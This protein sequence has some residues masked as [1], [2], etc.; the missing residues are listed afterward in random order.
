MEGGISLAYG[1]DYV[2]SNEQNNNELLK[3]KFANNLR[4]KENNDIERNNQLNSKTSNFFGEIKYS[5]LSYLTA[6]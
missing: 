2:I 6:V 1:T 4:L 3:I 5:P